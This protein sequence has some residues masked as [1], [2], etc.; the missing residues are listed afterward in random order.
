MIMF[1]EVEKAALRKAEAPDL[2]ESELK[3]GKRNVCPLRW[4][5]G[6]SE[7]LH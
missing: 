5:K 7:A 4:T 1:R 2:S 6:A 3:G